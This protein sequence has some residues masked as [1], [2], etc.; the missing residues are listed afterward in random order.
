MRRFECIRNLDTDG[1]HGFYIQ[2]AAADPI[3]QRFPVEQFHD[4][5]MLR[6]LLFDPV[7]DA[8]VWMIER[9]RST[10]LALK[11]L[12]QRLVIRHCLRQELE[13]HMTAEVQVLRLI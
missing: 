11:T 4:D 1:K 12:K 6:V 10:S 8:D 13:R 5:E 3:S 7:N 2:S 9:G